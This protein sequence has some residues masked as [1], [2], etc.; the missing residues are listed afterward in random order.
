MTSARTFL[1]TILVYYSQID[2]HS[3]LSGTLCNYLFC[4]ISLKVYVEHLLEPLLQTILALSGPRTTIMVP[5]STFRLNYA[6]ISHSNKVGLFTYFLFYFEF[7][8]EVGL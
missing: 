5:C 2:C 7:V 3:T 1:G 6:L 4:C 8:N